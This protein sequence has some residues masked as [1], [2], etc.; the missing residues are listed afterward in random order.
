MISVSDSY[1]TFDIG[2]YFVICNP[3]VNNL[4]KNYSKYKNYLLEN[5]IIVFKINISQKN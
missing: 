2:K 4:I 3:S 1:N 5:H